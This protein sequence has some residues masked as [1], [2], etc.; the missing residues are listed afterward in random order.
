VQLF[1]G[2]PGVDPYTRVVSDVYQDLFGEGSFIGKGIYDV[3]S[4]E[5]CCGDF[6]ENTILSHDLLEGAYARSGLLSDVTLYEDYPSRYATDIDRRHRWMRGDWQIATWLLP[7]VAGRL[8]HRVGN[9]ISA[10][11]WWKIC[12]N[13]R[14]SLV[15]VA[16][17]TLLL[18]SWFV[19]AVL[20]SITLA[21]VLMVVVLPTL[22]SS[23][24]ELER[25][26]IDLPPLMHLRATVQSL[27]QPLAQ[28]LLTLTFLPYEAYISLDAILRTWFR[29]VWTKRKLLE[30]K[31]ASD[32]ERGAAGSLKETL[33]SMAPAPTLAVSI[34]LAL[35]IFHP[36]VVPIA[37]P[38]LALWFTSPIAAWWLSRPIE[39]SRPQLSETQ[40]TFLEQLARRTWRYF[41]EFVTAEHNWLPPDNVQQNPDLL[42]APRTSPTNIGMALLADLAA[43][44]FGYCSAAQLLDRTKKT[45]AT[46]DRMERYR[47][48]LFNWYDTRSLV[49]LVPRYV[50]TVDSGNLL[51]DLLVLASGYDALYD[52]NI[53][54]PRMFGGLRDTLR[55]ARDVARGDGNPGVSADV[56]RKME[57]QIEDLS[58]AS[59][60]T[61]TAISAL[62]RLRAVASEIAEAAG[63]DEELAWWARTYEQS[64]VAHQ[65][66]LLVLAA[67]TQLPAPPDA[68]WEHSSPT[69]LG[70]LGEFRALLKKIDAAIT[71]REVA[72]LPQ[73]A[74]RVVDAILHEAAPPAKA[75]LDQFMVALH[76]SARHADERLQQCSSI[77]AECR[78]LAEMDFEMLYDRSR[79]LFSIGYNVNDRRL[80]A[81]FYDLLAS[82]A[83]LASFV[84]I[85]QGKFGQEHW[86]ALGRLLTSAGHMPAL[87]SW[88]GS[89]FE[90]LMPL[91][92]MPTYEGTL[93]DRTYQA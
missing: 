69:Q 37:G 47:G 43:Y 29:V 75:W 32:S 59:T 12:D 91:L 5:R 39:P 51:A 66:D 15:P 61:N 7:A 63:S 34:F 19:S 42:A 55:V 31:T 56:L 4:F 64:C 74:H 85:A 77:A 82:E 71:L 86:F 18:M 8:S 16:M 92:V 81:S 76:D 87:L 21:F 11:S 68:L 2:D 78:Q 24:V 73:M 17:L 60:A 83:R 80:D 52:T 70:R 65:Q 35:A 67:W 49:P 79:D 89:V 23:L 30:W 46:L 9:P 58:R 41:E 54:P 3:D 14:R 53:V 20:A 22:L 28:C 6:P 40:Q 84:V 90:Y 33:R 25:R 36:D 50:S 62:A 48:H 26:P 88:S 44:D 13:L 10:L 72:E 45:L 93:L 57:R 38:L 1:A 27:R